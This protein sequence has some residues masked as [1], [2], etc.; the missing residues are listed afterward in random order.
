MIYTCGY[1]HISY[2]V[3]TASPT[4]RY[5]KYENRTLKIIGK[6]FSNFNFFYQS[7]KKHKHHTPD[8]CKCQT[9]LRNPLYQISTTNPSI[10]IWLSFKS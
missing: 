1:M 3:E 4:A 2:L 9:L 8:N 6:K 10:W 5:T 7:E